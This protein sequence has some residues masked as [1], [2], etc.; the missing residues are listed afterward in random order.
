MRVARRTGRSLFL[1]GL[2]AGTILSGGTMPGLAQQATTLEE[3]SVTASPVQPAAKPVP[4]AVL[5]P[6]PRTPTGVLP[7]VTDS[8]SSVTVVTRSEIER[9]QPTQLGDAL[10]DKPGLSASTFAPGAASR[11]IIRGLDNTRVRIQENGVGVGDVSELS[12]DHAVP[13]NPIAADRIEVVRGPAALRYGSQAIG[14]VVAAENNRVPTFIPVGGIAGRVTT[15]Y[16]S[17]DNGYNTAA[18]VDAGAGNV[19]VHADG[20]RSQGDSYN[21]PAGIQANSQYVSQGGAVGFSVIGDR[22]FVGISYSHYDALYGIP[23]GGSAERR[24]LLD[25]VQDRLLARG[26]YRPLEGPFAVIRFWAGGSVYKHNESGLEDDGLRTIGSTFKSRE[27]EGRVEAQHVP[28][29]L[30]FGVLTGA[31]GIQSDR[32]VLGTSGE[33]GGLIAPTDARANALYLFEEL[34]LPSG[35][36]VQAA[37][38]IEGTRAAGTA[39]NFP[40]DYLPGPVDPL[41]YDRRR[42][43]AP[44]SASFGVLQDLP[45]DFVGSLTASYV[46][47]APSV[48]ELYSRGPH[49][50]TETFEIGDPNLKLERARTLE[51]GIR[52]AV[53]PLRLD[54]TGYITRYTGFIYKRETGT[55]CG[56]E[57]STCGAEDELRQIVY[58][59]AN[60]QFYGAEI[61]AQLDLIPVGNGFIGLD[62]QYD[63]VRA[64]FDNGSFVPRI[65]PHRVGGGAYLR[66]D[67]WYARV[68]LLHAFAHTETAPIETPTPGW[69]D[70]RAEISYTKP[71]DPAVYGA[72]E[73]TLGLQGRNL[74]DD[75]IRNS[76]SFKKDE[77]LLPGR[78]LRLFLTAR[79]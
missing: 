71:L 49:E 59:Q 2:S 12:E 19:A 72:S 3:L 25:P 18:S 28:V 77:I 48:L 23:G 60:A 50:A 69:D 22:G 67:G 43:F 21:T 47:R 1:A 13:I 24:V 46:E 17:V 78:N 33:A 6:L 74:L 35:T 34:A 63:F 37:G 5:Q 10:F 40:G 55:F 52:R 68:F 29:D 9:S 30:S 8:F 41:E 75:R 62:A 57:F 51:L 39:T 56:D 15:G 65:P 54:A 76:A 73:I 36:R 70:L 31:V 26:E 38:R 79:F 14:G 7:V 45:Y 53:G 27:V 61:G 32:R 16:S 44:K 20:F 64:Q 42:R 58:T 4:G 11:P 66:A